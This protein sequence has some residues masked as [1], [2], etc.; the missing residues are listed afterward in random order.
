MKNLFYLFLLLAVLSFVCCTG[1]NTDYRMLDVC[2]QKV[3]DYP[4]SVEVLLNEIS[5][6]RLQGESEKRYLLIKMMVQDAL[7]KPFVSLDTVEMVADYYN[8]K[9]NP[10]DRVNAN[11]LMG[12][13]NYL[14]GDVLKATECYNRCLEDSVSTDDA[15]F[16]ILLSKV[17]SQLSLIYH[18]QK[19][20]DW[21]EQE[22]RWAMFY[23]ERADDTL[24]S[25]IYRQFLYGP[26]Y[27]RND[28]EGVVKVVKEVCGMLRDMGRETE[29]AR[30]CTILM[31]SYL[32]L[33]DY[34]SAKKS[35]EIFERE[36]GSF[37]SCGNI[38]NG[39]EIYY[40]KK[41]RY[42][43]GIEKY[44]S[45]ELYFRK[46]LNFP[47]DFNNTEAAYCCLLTL[48]RKLGITDSIGKY[49]NLYCPANDSMH[50]QMV[51]EELVRSQ[52]MY[53][54]K[55]YRDRLAEQREEMYVRRKRTWCAFL[56]LMA[57]L[58]GMTVLVR[59]F[60]RRYKISHRN[61]VASYG[62][63]V[64]MKNAHEQNAQKMMREI[65]RLNEEMSQMSESM[66]ADNISSEF[67]D[68]EEE[69]TAFLKLVHLYAKKTPNTSLRMSREDWAKVEAYVYKMR[70]EFYKY[71][72]ARGLSENERHAV[73][74]T[75]LE[76]TSEEIQQLI[77]IRG[78]SYTNMKSRIMG[79]LFLT[80]SARDFTKSI[81]SWE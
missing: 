9:G 40:S 34:V 60:W 15:R 53:N 78:N 3:Y 45:A 75:R 2:A 38:I 13:A 74:L 20:P 23:A 50:R 43:M 44:D 67:S 70:P 26:Y 7:D 6:D 16:N 24:L 17:H 29:A 64:Q 39:K 11:Y 48:Y 49:A 22:I 56:S 65:E 73:F 21:E 58:F 31:N 59:R 68:N 81:L 79:K 54:Y 41:G 18:E 8:R 57:V 14:S 1:G 69:K 12:R 76:F 19:I 72:E 55:L 62:K 80:S 30:M 77:G 61:L 32:E 46:L 52:Q 36:S 10:Q 71:V 51:S 37:D 4:N 66:K 5:E 35:M 27:Q 25:L 28:H 33:G 47:D 63:V 42:Y